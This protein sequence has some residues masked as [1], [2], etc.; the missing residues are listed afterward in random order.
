MFRT[1][2]SAYTDFD[3][4]YGLV[5]GERIGPPLAGVGRKILR[6][7]ALLALLAGGG[8][9]LWTGAVAWPTWLPRN[10]A[11]VSRWIEAQPPRLE[12][13]ATPTLAPL[14]DA[15]RQLAVKLPPL[16][17][18]PHSLASPAPVP[19]AKPE[20]PPMTTG[21]L[22][23]EPPPPSPAEP[24]R[25][26]TPDPSDPLQ[27][28][29][30]AIGLHPEVSRVLLQRMSAA[31]YR[32]AEFAI[33]SALNETPDDGVFVWPRQRKPELAL[34][35]V[36]FVVGAAPSC[37]R[38]VVTVV[39]DGWLTTAPPMEKCGAEAAG[40]RRRAAANARAE[41]KP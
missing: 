38:Y 35:R 37:R 12:R 7:G 6:R 24:L 17:P 23:S 18:P 25:P 13:T 40:P 21:A 1:R 36:R 8:W 31:D 14:A 27:V 11:E 9:S 19:E 16:E 34:F 33:R 15:P 22:P 4:D 41:P 5:P 2:R 20:P 10:W 28:R 30:A 26:A 39:K 29:A 32:N 3:A